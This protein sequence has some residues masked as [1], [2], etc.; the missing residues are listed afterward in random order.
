MPKWTNKRPKYSG[1]YNRQ[2]PSG[3][4]S[5]WNVFRLHGR[6]VASRWRGG[7]W[8][9]HDVVNSMPITS[10]HILWYGPI[11]RPEGT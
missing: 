4:L 11:P 3:D 1:L 6:L 2:A 5:V 7:Q 9:P 10:P 8:T